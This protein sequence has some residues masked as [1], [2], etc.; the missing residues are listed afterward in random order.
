M[1]L[2]KMDLKLCLQSREGHALTSN[3]YSPLCSF[4]PLSG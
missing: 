1:T 3:E 4:T 2:S